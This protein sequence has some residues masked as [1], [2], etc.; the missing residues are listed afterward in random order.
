MTSLNNILNE[1][2][3]M[4]ARVNNTDELSRDYKKN[5]ITLLDIA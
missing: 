5:Y 2:Q 4:S 1:A 3:L